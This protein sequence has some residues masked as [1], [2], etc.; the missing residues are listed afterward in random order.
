MDNQSLYKPHG[1]LY[2]PTHLLLPHQLEVMQNNPQ[3][4][5]TIVWH[6]RARKTTTA[7][8]ELVKQA[9][10]RQGVYWHVFPTYSEAKDAVWRDP[11][12]I[13]RIIPPEMIV[14]KNNSELFI[15][16]RNNSILKLVG[17]DNPDSL[18]GAGP[19]GCVLDEFATMKFEAW[20]IIE[21]I[22]RANGGWCW[23]IGT[24][25][26]KNHL[27]DFYQRGQGGHSEWGS[28]LLDG[29]HSGII[30]QE[31]LAEMRRSMTQ[32]MYA[33]EIMC[34]FLESEGTVFRGV[35][36]AMT[37]QPEAPKPQHIYVMGVDLAKVTDFTVLTVYD[38]MNNSQVYQDRFQTLEWPFQKAKIAT[39]A[40]HYNNALTII[41][42]TGIGDPIADDLTRIGV[43]I[44]PFKI[45][46]QTKKDLIEKLSIWIEQK[47]CT[48]L[49]IQES[50][51]E[52][53]NFSYEI[54]PTGKI[55]YN[56][57]QGYHDDIVISHALAIHS[58]TP[59]VPNLIT[60]EQT[61]I[62]RYKRSLIQ[63][64]IGD[65]RNQSSE[66]DQQ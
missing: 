39:I 66:W 34:S 12:M 29:E 56:A 33:Q 63:Q 14:D 40:K 20:E 64:R 25:K 23:F 8:Y 4:F 27:Y 57:R 45:T 15:R 7:I 2:P 35:R 52:F 18:R 55:R 65:Q 9:H 28:W 44:E 17:A 1:V 38:R 59:I 61:P 16:F 47:K 6:R 51:L 49:P 24:P 5:K 48:L 3:R 11:Q 58:L 60:E 46:E 62:Q 50:T 31:Q 43:A 13:G 30:S 36:E 54:G 26:G 21:P 37:S 42:A 22:L 53:D 10:M 19:V 32:K 41:D